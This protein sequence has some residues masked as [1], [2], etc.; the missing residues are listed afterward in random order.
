M[1]GSDH[2]DK[3]IHR[4]KES[5]HLKQER[6]YVWATRLPPVR[7]VR[8]L[9]CGG[10]LWGDRVHVVGIVVRMWVLWYVNSPGMDGG[11]A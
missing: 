10:W 11:R 3:Y 6:L 2:Y 5:R 7:R 1:D 9:S 4:T 8:A